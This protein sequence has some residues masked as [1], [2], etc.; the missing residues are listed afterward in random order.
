M[1]KMLVTL[2]KIT[3]CSMLKFTAEFLVLDIKNDSL[4]TFLIRYSVLRLL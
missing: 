1:E 3:P 4:K 2:Q